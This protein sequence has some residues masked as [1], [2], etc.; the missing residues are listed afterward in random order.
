MQAG[1]ATSSARARRLVALAVGLVALAAPTAAQAVPATGINVL[2]GLPPAPGPT[3]AG[4][5]TEY[6][7][8]FTAPVGLQDNASSAVVVNAAGAGL[9]PGTIFPSSKPGTP[10]GEAFYT[11]TT[12]DSGG[13]V[14]APVQRS[15][16]N[17]TVVIPTFSTGVDASPGETVRVGIGYLNGEDE[18]K[19]R[20]PTTPCASCRL[21]VATAPPAPTTGADFGVSAAYAVEEGPGFLTVQSGDDQSAQVGADFASPLQ[22]KLVDG[23]GA[24][25]ENATVTFAAPATGPSGTFADGGG[26]EDEATTDS[27][28]IATSSTLTANGETGGWE[29][30]ATSD[31]PDVNSVHFALENEV[32]DAAT[33][34]LELDP[35]S[36][37]GNGAET[38]QATATV[39]DSFDNPVPGESVTFSTDGGHD[40]SATTSL[41]GGR[42]R[43]TITT[44]TE[45]GLFTAT[46]TDT[47]PSPDI[48]DTANFFQS[49]DQTA[50]T[51]SITDKPS[52]SSR[53]ARVRFSFEGD[54]ADIQR[55]E[56]RLD[57]GGFERCQ[58]PKRYR[59]GVG[60]HIF[61]VRARDFSG[62]TG[63]ADRYRFTRVPKR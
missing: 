62:N 27:N 6:T 40:V 59:V 29:V 16:G 50:P 14:I 34:D 56:C 31:V 20:N 8:V 17:Q 48:A 22:A 38:I 18:P 54:S 13:V 10:G 39:K 23:L 3:T 5:Q 19:V 61:K 60:S 30:D 51:V 44:T 57:G 52:K 55:F 43:A 33:V 63:P 12:A 26:L 53:R 9:A 24:P 42:Y 45:A 36:V 32:G 15:N 2:F 1:S 21:A 58:S 41:N 49:A 25:V 35:T 46:A 4:A 47:T 37:E 28:G 11:I 7:I